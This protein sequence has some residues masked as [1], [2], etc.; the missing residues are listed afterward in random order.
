[1]DLEKLMMSK[2]IMDR[3][4]TMSRGQGGSAPMMENFNAPAARYNINPEIL[5]ENVPQTPVSIPSAS[6]QMGYPK[7]SADA[8]QK[9]RL[10]DEI[11]RLMIEH[12]I[13]QPGTTTGPTLSNELIEKAS[14]LMG[15]KKPTQPQKQNVSESV[16]DNSSLRNMLKEVV[17]EVLQENGLMTESV[18]KTNDK[19]VFQV[20][21]HVFEGKLTKVKKLS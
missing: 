1:M 16:M 10:P 5:S 12:P 8:I 4:S 9:S 18:E 14:K 21:K 7:A 13:E 2:A 6:N 19:F 3:H 17:K 15:T 20:G 11:K